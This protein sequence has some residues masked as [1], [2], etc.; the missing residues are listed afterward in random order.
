MLRFYISRKKFFVMAGEAKEITKEQVI[1]LFKT[2]KPIMDER[3]VWFAY[4]KEEPIA[5]FINI[6]DLNQ[7]FKHFN[8]KF[9]WLQ[10]LRLLCMKKNLVG[11][12]NL[13]RR[14]LIMYRSWNLSFRNKNH[15]YVQ[16]YF[17]QTSGL[18]SICPNIHTGDPA[19]QQY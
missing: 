14:I 5:M 13:T 16:V 9:G 8:G 1:K 2:M 6:P 3:T 4:Y 10:K 19:H 12:L 17:Y 11:L 7:Y 15:Y 18:T